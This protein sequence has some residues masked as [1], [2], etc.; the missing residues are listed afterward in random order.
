M[1]K[2][3]NL[4]FLLFHC[5]NHNLPST[6]IEKKEFNRNKNLGTLILSKSLNNSQ[7]FI[8]S[9]FNSN[10]TKEVKKIEERKFN[11][12]LLEQT[13]PV[14]MHFDPREKKQKKVIKIKISNLIRN[15][16]KEIH[17][18]PESCTNNKK[19]FIKNKYKDFL[20]NF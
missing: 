17:V 18:N 10:L 16:N 8:K 7:V 14:S 6:H 13:S 19:Q 11:D 15:I 20:E 4:D 1:I 3:A 5:N 2:K 9:K 12:L